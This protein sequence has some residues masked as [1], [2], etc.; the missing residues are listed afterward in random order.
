MWSGDNI[1]AHSALSK[2]DIEMTRKTADRKLVWSASPQYVTC[3]AGDAVACWGSVKQ[4]KV[5][6][7]IAGGVRPPC[8]KSAAS[9]IPTAS[10]NIVI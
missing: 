3:K 4:R 8:G 10:Q 7:V 2:F 9:T 5:A 1:I 6:C